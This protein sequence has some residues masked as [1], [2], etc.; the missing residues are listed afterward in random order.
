[1]RMRVPVGTAALWDAQ[2][3]LQP[4]GEVARPH[5]LR[6]QVSLKERWRQS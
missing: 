6:T 4:V 2:A 5:A 1:M 3:P